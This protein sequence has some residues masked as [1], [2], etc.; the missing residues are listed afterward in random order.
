KEPSWEVYDDTDALASTAASERARLER[1]K[2]LVLDLDYFDQIS[3]HTKEDESESV[4]D[5]PQQPNYDYNNP[6]DWD[7]PTTYEEESYNNVTVKHSNACHVKQQSDNIQKTTD[8]HLD[9]VLEQSSKA[10]PTQKKQSKKSKH[11]RYKLPSKNLLTK[12]PPVD[13]SDE[14]K[15]INENIDKLERTFKSFGVDAKVV[16]ANL[17]PSV[18]KYEIEPAIGVK[19]SKIVSLSDDIALSLAARD[20]RMEA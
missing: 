2:D 13:Q 14:Y 6:S 20:I 7:A 1:D 16:K 9:S 19:V 15:R 12:I 17:G 11:K 4:V 3:N 5:M 8:N 18:T 10:N